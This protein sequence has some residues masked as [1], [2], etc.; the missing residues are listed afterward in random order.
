MSSTNGGACQPKRDSSLSQLAIFCDASGAAHHA[1]AAQAASGA[2][3]A[4][5]NDHCIWHHHRGLLLHACRRLWC[6]LRLLRCCAAAPAGAGRRWQGLALRRRLHGALRRG[7]LLGGCLLLLL[8]GCG[9]RRAAV[10]AVCVTAAVGRQRRAINDGDAILWNGPLLLRWRCLCLRGGSRGAW[11]LLGGGGCPVLLLRWRGLR[12]CAPGLL[13]CLW[14]LG[15]RGPIRLLCRRRCLICLLVRRRGR[16][17]LLR[18]R[19]RAPAATSPTRWHCLPLR[20]EHLLLVGLL[21]GGRLLSLLW[22]HRLRKG[23]GLRRRQR[24]RRLLPRRR[25]GCRAAGG[26]APSALPLQ[27]LS[28]ILGGAGW[29]GTAVPAVLLIPL[30]IRRVRPAQRRVGNG[31]TRFSSRAARVALTAIAQSWHFFGIWG[32]SGLWHSLPNAPLTWPSP[33]TPCCPP[34]LKLVSPFAAASRFSSPS[35]PPNTQLLS[36]APAAAWKLSRMPSFSLMARCAVP[37][38]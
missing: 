31:G 2:L 12:S 29:L 16:R 36:A 26:Q 10:V 37:L 8:C 22:L 13:V 32:R 15:W 21:V 23:S 14:L 9:R 4:A 3:H 27:L 1:A 19:R 28:S 35:A 5:G 18:G 38:Q 11:R 6:A 25:R 20:L 7:G 17:L 33:C 34:H 30:N 24:G